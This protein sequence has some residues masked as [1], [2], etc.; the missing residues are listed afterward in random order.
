MNSPLKND[1]RLTLTSITTST[2]F[3]SLSRWRRRLYRGPKARS[4]QNEWK[5]HEGTQEKIWR[6]QKGSDLERP[7]KE[8]ADRLKTESSN[9]LRMIFLSLASVHLIYIFVT[10]DGARRNTHHH[11]STNPTTQTYIWSQH[12]HPQ[13]HLSFEFRPSLLPIWVPWSSLQPSWKIKIPVLLPRS[14]RVLPNHFSSGQ[15]QQKNNDHGIQVARQAL[16][17][18]LLTQRFSK[19][20]K[21]LVHWRFQFQQLDWSRLLRRKWYKAYRFDH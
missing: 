10:A 4:P 16:H 2:V 12:F 14:R 21:T 1:R 3:F 11:P 9:S 20:E 6:Y 13:V 5:V 19:K 8:I 17:S 7:Q 15:F 18:L